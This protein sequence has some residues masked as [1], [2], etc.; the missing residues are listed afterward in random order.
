MA[1]SEGDQQIADLVATNAAGQLMLRY[2]FELQFADSTDPE[3]FRAEADQAACRTSRHIRTAAVEARSHRAGPRAD[4]VS[5]HYAADQH[6][7]AENE[8]IVGNLRLGYSSTP[9]GGP[10]SAR[11]C[12]DI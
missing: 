4:E 2:L 6:A 8:L 11:R 7:I 10:L 5:D 3:K 9:N 12:S 1:L